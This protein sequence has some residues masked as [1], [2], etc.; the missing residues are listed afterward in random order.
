MVNNTPPP[1]RHL[2]KLRALVFL[3]RVQ[4]NRTVF[5]IDSQ[6]YTRQACLQTII[7]I[8][9]WPSSTS[10]EAIDN[11][12]KLT[13]A[14]E[15]FT[16]A[17]ISQAPP[18]N[19]PS[20]EQLN[21]WLDQSLSKAESPQAT[22]SKVLTAESL[23]LN[24]MQLL[25]AR[26]RAYEQFKEQF[27]QAAKSSLIQDLSPET[28]TALT[29][30]IT[31]GAQPPIMTTMERAADVLAEQAA[32]L[33]VRHAAAGGQF[34]QAANQ[35]LVATLEQSPEG[36]LI[37]ATKKAKQNFTQKTGAILSSTPPDQLT[38]SFQAKEK[39]Q[40][41]ATPT[42][43][44][45]R[46]K[47]I[48][49]A[50]LTP[51]QAWEASLYFE[52]RLNQAYSPQAALIDTINHFVASAQA[53]IVYQE[54]KITAEDYAVLF[55]KLNYHHPHDPAFQPTSP[56]PR[57]SQKAL[58]TIN[59]IS[60]RDNG[61]SI[62]SLAFR[63]YLMRKTPEE[64]EAEIN[65]SPLKEALD[66]QLINQEKTALAWL[67][68]KQ[69]LHHFS[70]APDKP[71]QLN[72]KQP[73]QLI[74]DKTQSV[75][76]FERRLAAENA[77]KTSGWLKKP[78][79]KWQAFWANFAAQNPR[80]AGVANFLATPVKVI[81]TKVAGKLA[82]FGTRWAT[83][84]GFKGLAGKGLEKIGGWL[85]EKGLGK[86]LGGVIG[87]LAGGPLGGVIGVVVGWLSEKVF[88]K[89]LGFLKKHWQKIAGALGALLALL[90]GV[91]IKAV[92]AIA[93]WLGLA[94][95]LYGLATFNPFLIF[96]GFSIFGAS[97][98][99]KLGAL[100]AQAG[101]FSG[102][103]ASLGSK[104]G[105]WLGLT[106]ATAIPNYVAAAP[107]VALSGIAA[108]TTFSMF[109]LASAFVLPPSK[110]GSS[111]IREAGNIVDFSSDHLANQVAD[112]TQKVGSALNQ[113]TWTSS[114]EENLKNLLSADS[115]AYLQ[116]S[117]S[118]FGSLQC[119][120]FKL[121]IEKELG[122]NL[123]Q[124]N[125]VAFVYNHPG[126]TEISSDQVQAGDNA[127]WGPSDDCPTQNAQEANSLCNSNETCCGH[128]GIITNVVGNQ[129]VYVTS[130]NA[131]GNGSVDT[132]E[133]SRHNITKIIRCQ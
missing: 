51:E 99:S 109:V 96:T 98:W 129:K 107:F 122:V 110:G 11:P 28:Q 132:R 97:I 19:R 59:R 45:F 111:S 103:M 127:V 119:V 35:A 33:A 4:K 67:Y 74:T 90:I 25:I 43:E 9:N 24:D 39:L 58:L 61:P 120:G 20:L 102:M 72:F 118:K 53:E 5:T 34:N 75:N 55:D 95:G 56:V 100:W 68:Q 77:Q 31:E 105:S 27:K 13:E 104:A 57:I 6:E 36:S 23:S 7:Q 126:C 88:K 114:L 41:A 47:L 76:Y 38:V 44:Q 26:A 83:E 116:N 29:T 66:P 79:L 22:A 64:F 10:P 124:Q 2:A 117:I 69:E 32:N 37:L 42:P 63:A 133:F 3:L 54:L 80:L 84:K 30:E 125:A 8:L 14:W 112:V 62:R 17:M 89:S 12:E 48:A 108:G 123:P 128:L 101:G 21:Y 1:I 46:Q 87:T 121:A 15:V 86:I 50:H 18:A 49:I 94:M 16:Q 85:S 65:A 113:S 71:H 115:L 91:L 131:N 40:L 78:K 81:R 106:T 92:A 70:Q 93:P 82:G 60:Q 73:P 130:A 52:D